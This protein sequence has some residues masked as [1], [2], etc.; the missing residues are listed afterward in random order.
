MGLLSL[1]AEDSTSGTETES[2]ENRVDQRGANAATSSDS[3]GTGADSDPDSTGSPGSSQGS[4]SKACGE[5]RL[6]PALTKLQNSARTFK[7]R[8]AALVANARRRLARSALLKVPEHRAEA[9]RNDVKHDA[10][11]HRP[12]QNS[13]YPRSRRLRLL[14]SFLKAWSA[15]LVQFFNQFSGE[16]NSDSSKMTVHHSLT[17]SIIDDT[18]MRLSTVAPDVSAW[19]AAG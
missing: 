18:N 8:S 13:S 5:A 3:N 15:A 14:V 17:T 10:A 19:K 16:A 9:F 6:E 1:L 7:A 4:G 11:L 12:G 2:C